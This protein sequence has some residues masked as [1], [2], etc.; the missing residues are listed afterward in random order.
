M[1]LYEAVFFNP[2][3]IALASLMVVLE[4]MGYV[5]FKQNLKHI[6]VQYDLGFDFEA[7]E[8]CSQM[9]ASFSLKNQSVSNFAAI[10]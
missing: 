10:S 4:E 3:T 1:S 8:K 6:I 2:S 9:I 7:V 5:I